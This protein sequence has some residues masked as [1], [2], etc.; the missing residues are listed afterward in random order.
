MDLVR[1]I[2]DLRQRTDGWRAGGKTV[3]FVPTM[4]AL[5]EGHLALVRQAHRL[6]DCV[7]VSLFVNPKQ[8][9]ANEDLGVY[10]RDEAGD[11]AKLVAEGVDLLY[12]PSVATMYGENALTTVNVPGLGDVLEGEYRPGFFT[13]VATVVTKLLLQARADVAVFGEKDYQQLQVIK[14][15]VTDLDIPVQVAPGETVREADG[16]ALS[17]RN[18][19]LSD[20]ERVIAPVLH[21]VLGEVAAAVQAGESPAA[22]EAAAKEKVLAAGF[23]SID[24]LCVRDSETLHPVDAAHQGAKRVLVAAHLGTTRLIDNV[25][26]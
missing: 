6:C 13:G 11:Q 21:R 17:S 14:R 22:A 15:L 5:H 16:L 18:A 25:A 26:I 12:A 9:G 2:E 1:T 4:G 10:P 19:Y 23:E 24:Y 7:V 20:Q 8:F 3:A